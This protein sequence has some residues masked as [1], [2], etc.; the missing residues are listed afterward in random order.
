MTYLLLPRLVAFLTTSAYFFLS[1]VFTVAWLSSTYFVFR[2]YSLLWS[3]V[4][5]VVAGIVLSFI[6]KICL[7]I[8]KL[9]SG[10]LFK[11]V[12]PKELKEVVKAT[13]AA[14]DTED[15]I[16]SSSQEKNDQLIIYG[17]DALSVESYAII[18]CSSMPMAQRIVNDFISET[19]QEGWERVQE[20][21]IPAPNDPNKKIRVITVKQLDDKNKDFYFDYSKPLKLASSRTLEL[22]TKTME[23]SKQK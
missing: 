3:I 13:R 7:V 18:N 16:N 15:R 1:G 19:C 6:Y 10:L 2:D 12:S 9:L 22:L 5:L 14:R 23:D 17:G 11:L 8:I 4:W 20:Y 21:S